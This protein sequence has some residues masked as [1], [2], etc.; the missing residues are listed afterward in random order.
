V[1]SEN[2]HLHVILYQGTIKAERNIMDSTSALLLTRV[3]FQDAKQS[4][5]GGERPNGLLRY[6]IT[7]LK[8]I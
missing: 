5:I 2:F 7:F 8:L 1:R 4:S 3:T 6:C